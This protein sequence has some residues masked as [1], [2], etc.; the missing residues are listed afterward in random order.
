MT[1]DSIENFQPGQTV[2]S[3]DDLNAIKDF[4][5]LVKRGISGQ[6]P[7]KV[8][9]SELGGI[10]ISIDERNEEVDFVI[11]KLEDVSEDGVIVPE[12][13]GSTGIDDD[14]N[15]FGLSPQNDYEGS[16]WTFINQGGV[17]D[18]GNEDTFTSVLDTSKPFIATVSAT[19]VSGDYVGAKS[20]ESILQK[21]FPGFRVLA[22]TS[23]LTGG[24]T[25]LVVRRPID[26]M[27]GK[28]KASIATDASGNVRLSDT[29]GTEQSGDFSATNKGGAVVSGDF[30][31][32]GEDASG[33]VFFKSTTGG[34]C[35]NGDCPDSCS[36]FNDCIEVQWTQGM[37][38]GS[39][40]VPAVCDATC[41]RVFD[42][43]GLTPTCGGGV[44]DPATGRTW[45]VTINWDACTTIVF[46]TVSKCT[47]GSITI[48]GGAFPGVI[49]DQ[50]CPNVISID[51]IIKLN[52]DPCTG[53]NVFPCCDA[54]EGCTCL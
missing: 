22:D 10:Q 5:K 52:I 53:T 20:G 48:F 41:I 17:D 26:G 14:G 47:G 21:D 28:A 1:I 27:L 45:S 9:S 39:F 18:N 34:V 11:D 12:F 44:T 49:G 16:R 46:Y 30:I 54:A 32:L 36:Q 3:A 7:I 51:A 8:V 38:S 40:F 23:G 4:L 25:A 35:E 2:L 29:D 6:A 24:T 42:T 37:T 15:V 13:G 19:V 50:T 43:V 33:S 31:Q